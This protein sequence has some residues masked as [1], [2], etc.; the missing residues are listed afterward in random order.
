MD[1]S[2]LGDLGV[3]LGGGQGE[4]RAEGLCKFGLLAD[5]LLVHLF[6]GGDVLA[7]LAGLGGLGFGLG[8][9]LWFGW[10]RRRRGLDWR[11]WGRRWW[12]WFL[13]KLG[14]DFRDL[15]DFGRVGFLGW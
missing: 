15:L 5:F 12:C 13:L 7:L 14:L 2:L 9:G 6:Q 8:F 1:N 11:W 3:A 10:G 4:L